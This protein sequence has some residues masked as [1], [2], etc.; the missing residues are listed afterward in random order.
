MGRRGTRLLLTVVALTLPAGVFCAV[1]WAAGG[2]D[3]A[4]P[5]RQPLAVPGKPSIPAGDRLFGEDCAHCHSD[6]S[7]FSER[8]WRTSRTP[9]EVTRMLLGEAAGHPA[10]VPDLASAWDATAYVWTLPDDGARIRRGESLALQ[11]EKALRSDAL[12]VLLLHWNDL[13]DLKS[14]AWVLNHT[15]GEVDAL[16]RQLA[17]SRYTELSAADRRDLID[18]VFASFFT[19]PVRW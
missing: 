9:A 7:R 17:G 18:Y 4:R 11:A 16:M 13:Q 14:A 2:A 1:G 19:W 8:S 6:R 10:A 15:P 12:S 3:A 5:P